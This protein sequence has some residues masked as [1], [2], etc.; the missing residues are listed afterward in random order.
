MFA[1]LQDVAQKYNVMC[2]PTFIGFNSNGGYV[3][4][5]EGAVPAKLFDLVKQVRARLFVSA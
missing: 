3:D 4:R 1:G 2:M 5:I